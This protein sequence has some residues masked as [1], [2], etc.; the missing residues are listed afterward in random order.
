MDAPDVD[1]DPGHRVLYRGEPFTGEVAEYVGGQM[2]YLD[3][4]AE[5]I[6]DGLSQGWYPDGS[7]KS[8]GTVRNGVATGEFREWHPNGALKARRFFDD[9]INT[10]A[11]GF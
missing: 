1:G 10:V 3:V 11:F 7:R 8:L 2:V 4:Y 6:R 9:D 5:G